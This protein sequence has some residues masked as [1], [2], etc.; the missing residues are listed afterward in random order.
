M[1][2]QPTHGAS[3]TDDGTSDTKRKPPPRP[4]KKISTNA[5]D[6]DDKD[7]DPDDTP[8]N[9]EPNGETYEANVHDTLQEAKT[10]AHP[11]DVRVMMSK[12]PPD[13][14]SKPSS[15]VTLE[16][17][18]TDVRE[19]LSEYIDDYWNSAPDFP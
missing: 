17:K 14:Q 3:D 13:T 7:I 16:A 2:G 10:K 5:H 6:V 8:D 12:K 15:K 4:K 11:A 18:A 19:S 9:G 1:H